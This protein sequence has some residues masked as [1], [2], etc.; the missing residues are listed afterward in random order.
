MAIHD[1]LVCL[2]A[3]ANDYLPSL[4][5]VR[6]QEIAAGHRPE[7]SYIIFFDFNTGAMG[8]FA[9]KIG[10]VRFNIARYIKDMQESELWQAE[11]RTRR[12]V[13]A[14]EASKGSVVLV[15]GSFA[16]NWTTHLHICAK[17]DYHMPHAFS[18]GNYRTLNY[19]FNVTMCVHDV[20]APVVATD[21]ISG[22]RL[23]DT[24]RDPNSLK[25]DTRSA[26]ACG[27]RG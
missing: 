22:A 24:P 15:A 8:N 25:L 17:M 6:R 13:K 14:M 21:T 23:E 16:L 20:Y 27:R 2:E 7:D 26:K 4:P 12:L 1:R 5:D 19:S 9:E 3:V 10:P 11:A 18:E